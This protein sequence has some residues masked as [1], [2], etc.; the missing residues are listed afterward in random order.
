MAWVAQGKPDV[1][2]QVEQCQHNLHAYGSLS[3]ELC[4]EGEMLNQLGSL[5]LLWHEQHQFHFSSILYKTVLSSPSAIMGA[6]LGA[7]NMIKVRK[8]PIK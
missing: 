6:G 2:R 1:G 5:F 7:I 4:A 3:I 8:W